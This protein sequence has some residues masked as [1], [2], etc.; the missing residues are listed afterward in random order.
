MKKILES[1]AVEFTANLV[2]KL[3]GVMKTVQMVPSLQGVPLPLRVNMH[4]YVSE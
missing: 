1:R 4:M 2:S 3:I